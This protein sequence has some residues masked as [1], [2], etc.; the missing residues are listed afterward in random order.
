MEITCDTHLITIESPGRWNP[1]VRRIL[2]DTHVNKDLLYKESVLSITF[3]TIQ[4]DSY[5]G[6]DFYAKKERLTFYYYKS[7][8]TLTN[9]GT[10]NLPFFSTLEL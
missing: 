9:Q 7:P 8:N 5:K 3:E 10:H 1:S 2:E 4:K 6:K